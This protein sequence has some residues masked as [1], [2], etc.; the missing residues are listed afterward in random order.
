MAD[1]KKVPGVDHCLWHNN[2]KLQVRFQCDGS[3]GPDDLQRG[4]CTTHY[5]RIQ[6]YKKSGLV[7]VREAYEDEEGKKHRA[8]YSVADQEVMEQRLATWI[9]KGLLLESSGTRES[10]YDMSDPDSIFA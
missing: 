3:V 5:Q 7:P 8:E 1:K 2:E 4:N 9:D 6:A 10:K